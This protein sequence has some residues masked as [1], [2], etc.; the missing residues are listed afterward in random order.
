[1]ETY[2]F[3]LKLLTS[4]KRMDAA[5][6][7]E[8]AM[9]TAQDPET[10]QAC[11]LLMAHLGAAPLTPE[12]AQWAWQHYDGQKIQVNPMEEGER[13]DLGIPLVALAQAYGTLDHAREAG[14]PF[15]AQQAVVIGKNAD[16]KVG[17]DWLKYAAEQGSAN[18]YNALGYYYVVGKGVPKD[19]RQAFCWFEKGAEAGDDTA[20]YNMGISYRDGNGVAA[21]P[22]KMVYWFRQAAE[23]GN[24]SAQA[25]L[26]NCYRNGSGVAVDME[27]AL[28]WLN[29]AAEQEDPDA[30]CDLGNLYRTAAAIWLP[31]RK[32]QFT[33]SVRR[34]SRAAP[35]H[36]TTWETAI[37]WAMVWRRIWSRRQPGFEKAA[38]QG[39]AAAQYNL[40]ICYLGGS[41][42]AADPQEAVA[43]FQKAAEQGM[44]EAQNS[45]GTCYREGRGVAAD[46]KKSVYWY[47]KAAEQGLPGAQNDLGVWYQHG[48]GVE[49]EDLPRAAY[50]FR[51]AADQGLAGCPV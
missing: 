36:R 27:Q 12:T 31:T 40:G 49:R 37:T 2:G 16:P 50:W 4:G 8:Q 44:P 43:W 46:P 45:L 30:Q 33:G 15:D 28:Y 10:K 29:Q 9:N 20:Q 26:G 11:R 24:T 6:L 5:M 34:Q 35:G 48:V 7:L 17:I 42:V 14:L 47:Q 3:A 21:D 23:Q 25:T 41:G 32:R 22:E 19:P 38:D 51:K 39:D 18:A 13:H 1:M